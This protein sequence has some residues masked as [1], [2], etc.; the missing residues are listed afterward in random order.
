VRHL[1]SKELTQLLEDFSTLGPYNAETCAE[2]SYG[3]FVPEI[4]ILIDSLITV[5]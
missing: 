5:Y 2:F 3:P 4:K 1:F